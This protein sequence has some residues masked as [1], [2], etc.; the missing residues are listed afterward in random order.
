MG[1]LAA[2][3]RGTPEDK[4]RLAVIYVMSRTGD[5]AMSPADAEAL[6][7]ALRASGADGAAHSYVKRMASLNARL[8]AATA[9][10]AGAG[11]GDGGD[12]LDWADKLYGQS[13]N[14]VAKGVKSLLSGER[15]LPLARAVASVMANPPSHESESFA[16]FDPQAP[17]GAP[18]RAAP[19]QGDTRTTTP[20]CLSSAAEV[21][22]VPGGARTRAERTE[23]GRAAVEAG[24]EG[25]ASAARGRARGGAWC[26]ARRS[27]S[28]GRS[29][30]NS[31][32]NSGGRRGARGGEP[33]Q[34]A[35]RARRS[36]RRSARG[37]H[38]ILP[39]RVTR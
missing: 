17:R 37:N 31:S 30:S 39:A 36:A 2:T 23:A 18:A 15:R 6:E 8:D 11:A 34:R 13:V 32:E 19:R 5:D 29:S 9:G 38:V 16:V 24:W 10:G 12:L 33:G 21:S 20:S 28:R 35:K 7:G 4:L 3:G 27:L 22:R 1:L 26:T 14:A 25:E